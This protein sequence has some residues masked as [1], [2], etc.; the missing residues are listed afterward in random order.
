MYEIAQEVSAKIYL[1]IVLFTFINGSATLVN[2]SH[3]RGGTAWW[4]PTAN[5]SETNKEVSFFVFKLNYT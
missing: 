5:Y 3:F 4:K 2:A 1:A